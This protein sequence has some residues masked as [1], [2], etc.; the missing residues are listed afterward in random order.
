MRPQWGWWPELPLQK[1]NN[2][3]KG[4]V[5][6][7]Y[8]SRYMIYLVSTHL[9]PRTKTSLWTGHVARQAT[10]GP[11]WFVE[12]RE[13]STAENENMPRPWCVASSLKRIDDLP[14]E[15]DEPDD[16]L[17]SKFPLESTLIWFI[18]G[19]IMFQHLWFRRSQI[20]DI[21]YDLPLSD[22]LSAWSATN[23]KTSRFLSHDSFR[24][25]GLQFA[26]GCDCLQSFCPRASHRTSWS[27]WL[28]VLL[29]TNQPAN[30][31]NYVP[32]QKPRF[33]TALYFLNFTMNFLVACL[34]IWI[35]ISSTFDA[36]DVNAHFEIF[37]KRMYNLSVQ[38]KGPP[39]P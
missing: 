4:L 6:H 11:V 30:L 12:K 36:I 9:L 15:Q 21:L 5:S 23:Q 39:L 25:I 3:W 26:K 10:E 13:L 34:A 22:W 18:S 2:C 29:R 35:F 32:R 14:L 24:E 37:V 27:C 17:Q 1:H 28:H 8:W 16:I 38:N 20:G 33:C 31:P 7:I 19:A